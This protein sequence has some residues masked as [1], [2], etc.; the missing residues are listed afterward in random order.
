MQRLGRIASQQILLGFGELMDHWRTQLTKFH[1]TIAL[2]SPKSIAGFWKHTNFFLLRM[3]RISLPRQ[4][5]TIFCDIF[6][7]IF[8]QWGSA[9]YLSVQVLDVKSR[10]IFNISTTKAKFASF[11]MFT[12]P[13]GSFCMLGMTSMACILSSKI[14]SWYCLTYCQYNSSYVHAS[15][16]A[17]CN[18]GPLVILSAFDHGI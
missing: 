5:L 3:D 1:R 14:F 7:C 9:T 17:T 15:I 18:M 12:H 16:V 13:N 2:F 8:V 6:T 11:E 10:T 4:L